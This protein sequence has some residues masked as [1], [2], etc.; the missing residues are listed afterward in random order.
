VLSQARGPVEAAAFSADGQR[1]LTAGPGGLARI[2]RRDGRLVRALRQPSA[3]R[4]AIWSPDGRLVLTAGAD[5]SVRV[6]RAGDGKL[7]RVRRDVSPGPI[8]LDRRGDLLA[9]P[10]L[11]G[12]VGLWRLPS[13]RPVRPVGS[14]GAYL[15]AA[16]SPDGRLVAGA[17]DDGAIRLWDARTG[18]R[19]RVLP[20][21]RDAVTS[22]SF[23]PDGRS[24]VSASRDH[25]VHIWDLTPGPHAPARLRGHS[26]TVFGA[27]YN[28]DG[29]LI[30]SAGPTTAGVWDAAS[31]SLLV[32]LRAG[33]KHLTSAVFSPDGRRI[34][35]SGVDG[36]VRVYECAFCGGREQLAGAARERLAELARPLPPTLRR[37][38]LPQAAS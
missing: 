4:S 2:L 23:S 30:V 36:A 25:E 12:Q 5:G 29:Q 10:T 17:G 24:L 8:A 21:H 35:T 32:Y 31:G 9:G 20:G 33:A 27:S 13:L 19:R 28:P 6:W 38:Y 3:V 16:L 14:R 34:L 22:V 26:G 7:L 15:A 11:S 1:V 37:R 18:K